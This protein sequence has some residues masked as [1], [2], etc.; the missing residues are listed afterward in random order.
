MYY[1]MINDRMVFSDCKAIYLEDQHRWLSNPTEEEIFNAGWRV[2]VPPYIPP[3]PRTE[4]DEIDIVDAVKRMLQSSV[5]EMSDADALDVAAL[6]PTWAS[7]IGTPVTVGE[8]LWYDTKLYKVIQ[9]HTASQE[10]T[11]DITPA[12]YTEVSIEEWPEFVQPTGAQDAYMTGDKVTFEGQHY[13]CQ[14][15]NC[16]WSPSAYPAAWQLA[17]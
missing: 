13:I 7:K 2:Y 10:W 6:F 1:K 15:D 4:P 11:P 16:T 3:Q 9:A 14:I 17:E 5:N 12:L 8:R